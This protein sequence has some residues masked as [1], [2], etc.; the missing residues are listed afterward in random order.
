M[1]KRKK[2]SFKFLP[3]LYKYVFCAC[4]FI[5]THI[6]ENS[7]PFYTEFR[8]QLFNA[9]CIQVI[10]VDKRVRPF[11]TQFTHV[12]NSVAQICHTDN[13]FTQITFPSRTRSSRVKS[14]PISTYVM[15]I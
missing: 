5:S 3:T 2:S 8:T 9:K 6:W 7:S 13:A 14:A 4:I 10:T 11:F 15:L 1:R 12:Q